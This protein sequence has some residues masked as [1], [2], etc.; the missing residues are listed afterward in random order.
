ME[1]SKNNHRKRNSES[2]KSQ[3]VN[4]MSLSN[5]RLTAVLEGSLSNFNLTCKENSI[6][7]SLLIDM[8][9]KAEIR[10]KR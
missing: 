8:F 2:H 5:G 7:Y 6:H 1:V 10:V 3:N 9:R 4:V